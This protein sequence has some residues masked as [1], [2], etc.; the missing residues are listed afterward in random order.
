M[1]SAKN[2]LSK[3]KD[4]LIVIIISVLIASVATIYPLPYDLA[5]WRPCFLML[6]TLFWILCQTSWCGIWFAF[7]TGIFTDLLID[8]P[9]GQ[10]ALIYVLLTFSLRY[11]IREKR[12]LTFFM[13]WLITSLSIISYGLFLWGTQS[14]VHIHYPIMHRWPPI[15]SS[16]LAWPIIYMLL[17][18]WRI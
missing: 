12:V 4:P 9:L 15:L 8:A 18:K 2:S 5:V 10:S 17:K 14:A 3:N 16:I 13:L 11:F 1:L 6:V 7:A